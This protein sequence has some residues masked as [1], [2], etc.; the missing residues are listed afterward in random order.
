M[1]DHSRTREPQYERCLQ[2][3]EVKGL[4]P[5]GLM[6]NLTW[7]DDPKRLVFVLSRYKFVAKVLAGCTHVLEV[8]C[9]DAFATRIV[10]QEVGRVTAIDFDPAFIADATARLDP[11]WWIDLRVHDMLEGPV[12]G[13]FDGVYALDVLEHIDEGDE[14][15]FLAN[16]AASMVAT[17][18][19]IVGMP[20]L[21]SQAYASEH[22]R[23]GH[24]N[25]KDGPGLRAT[26]SRHF[27]NVVIFSMNDEVVHTGF[28]PLA[29][30]FLA[31]CTARK[32]A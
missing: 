28:Q 20:S 12:A 32:G 29:N 24:V 6:S 18:I 3:Q 9:A 16:M 27:H 31:V 26:L 10:L 7:N 22:S 2:V 19:C 5:L 1:D 30:Y 4:T 14:D 13:T 8:G 11:D 23:A 21:A 15:R 25:C 17:G